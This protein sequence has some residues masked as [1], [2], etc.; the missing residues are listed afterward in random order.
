[1][2]NNAGFAGYMPFIQ[3]DPDRADALI[4]VHV[5]ATTRL[6][7]AALPSMIARGEGAIINVASLLGF[8]A[9]VPN[10]SPM[11]KRAVYAACKGYIIAFT[12]ALHHELEGAGVQVQEFCPGGTRG[13]ELHDDIPGFD[14]SRFHID[15]KG[16]VKASLAGLRLGE[17]ICIPG[18]DE[19]GLIAQAQESERRILERAGLGALAQRYGA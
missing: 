8:S 13:T 6:T 7:R 14:D 9:S 19:P 16:I 15:A 5:L 1:V 4:R 18:L 10:P 12:E 17:V 3:L 11:P 2:I